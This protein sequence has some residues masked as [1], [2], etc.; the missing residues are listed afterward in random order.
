MRHPVST[1]G[2]E[3]RRTAV[4]CDVVWGAI[5]PA[6]PE[7]AHPSPGQ[8]PDRVRMVAPAA[9]GP[10]V[11][12][13]RPG[14]GVAGVVGEGGERQAQAFVT[15]PAER[16]AVMLAG[17]VGD[18]DDAGLRREVVGAEEALPIVA[19]LGEDLGRVDRPTAGERLDDGRIGMLLERSGDLLD[20]GDEGDE[21]GDGL[22]TRSPAASVS[23]SPSRLAGA[24][25][26]RARRSRGDRRPQ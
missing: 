24:A 12:G 26:R 2:D 3:R 17:G 16:D 8:D 11:D 20:L 19:E 21:D 18:G 1:L 22:R 5:L 15:G 4:A 14:R 7:H 10:A 6:A 9:Q 23:V 25:C 13:G